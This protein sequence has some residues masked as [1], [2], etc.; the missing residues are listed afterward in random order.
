MYNINFVKFY[1]A[2]KRATLNATFLWCM[3]LSKI[4]MVLLMK[5]ETHISQ[6]RAHKRIFFR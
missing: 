1:Q 5:L 3:E 4:I 2:G 6:F